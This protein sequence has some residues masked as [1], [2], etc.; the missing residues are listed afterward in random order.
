MSA[1]E[2]REIINHLKKWQ[3]KLSGKWKV[4]ATANQATIDKGDPFGYAELVKGLSV[5]QEQITL[6]ATDR[7]HLNHGIEFL[8]EELADALGKTHDRVRQ[9]IDKATASQPTVA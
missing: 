6:S 1:K 7:K 5:M 9:I 2:A 3:G 8:C 4:R